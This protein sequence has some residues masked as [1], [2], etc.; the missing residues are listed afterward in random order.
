MISKFKL[1]CWYAITF[2]LCNIKYLDLTLLIKIDLV[3]IKGLLN[4]FEVKCIVL[5]KWEWFVKW[6][7]HSKLC[8]TFGFKNTVCLSVQQLITCF[9]SQVMRPHVFWFKPIA[10][11]P[12]QWKHFLSCPLP[13]PLLPLLPYRVAKNKVEQTIL[14]AFLNKLNIVVAIPVLDECF[15]T[16]VS[17]AQRC[18][19]I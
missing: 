11:L 9:F 8:R 13:T 2:F 1:L 3:S 4:T 14:L 6:T 10:Y 5:V 19:Q 16:I 7:T 17:C 18:T 12:L 15:G